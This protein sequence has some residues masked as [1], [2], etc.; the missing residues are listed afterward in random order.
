MMWIVI[1]RVEAGGPGGLRKPLYTAEL[2]VRSRSLLGPP[3]FRLRRMSPIDLLHDRSRPGT[4]S[5]M[6]STVG[7]TRAPLSYCASLWAAKIEAAISST[8]LRPSST[9]AV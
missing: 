6:G 3:L 5:A 9:P 2:R 7:G 1:F 4:P 8:R